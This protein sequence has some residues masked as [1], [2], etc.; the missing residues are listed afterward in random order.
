MEKRKRLILVHI[1][2]SLAIAVSAGVIVAVLKFLLS[3][4][5]SSLAEELANLGQYWI[6]GLI[7]VVLACLGITFPDGFIS[8][9]ASPKRLPV[10]F[11]IMA[12]VVIGAIVY[13][14][15]L[16]NWSYLIR[17]ISIIF[18]L[19]SYCAVGLLI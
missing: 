19:F 10:H 18:L 1:L 16:F 14:S 4:E 12:K 3:D 8:I 17:W 15:L 2:Q 9:V 13:F 11:G 7:I 5:F 6:G